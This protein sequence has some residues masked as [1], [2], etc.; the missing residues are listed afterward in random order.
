RL[1]A[2]CRGARTLL[3]WSA[4]TERSCL[5]RCAAAIPALS[6]DVA[7]LL[8]RLEDAIPLVR[9][10]VYH[11]D[12]GGGFGL[13]R[14]LPALIPDLRHDALE[15]SDGQAAQNE[16]EELMF[17]AGPVDTAERE[18]VRGELMRYCELDTWGVARLIE[19]LEE[20]TRA[21]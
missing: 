9:D 7:L 2:A 1:S 20:H 16:L 4:S 13:K 15:I 11:P 10:H 21:S 14:V 18:R 6:H 3:A 19:V 5:K 12:F 8:E 17:P